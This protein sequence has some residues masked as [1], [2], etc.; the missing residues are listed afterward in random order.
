MKAFDFIEFWLYTQ[1]LASQSL[2]SISSI[3]SSGWRPTNKKKT[4]RKP[5]VVPRFAAGTSNKQNTFIIHLFYR[6]Y[7]VFWRSFVKKENN[8][9]G[10]FSQERPLKI[11][12][13]FNLAACAVMLSG[14][15]YIF[16]TRI[17]Q[18]AKS[19][20]LESIVHSTKAQFLGFSMLQGEDCWGEGSEGWK[21]TTKKQDIFFPVKAQR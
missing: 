17:L 11:N 20:S 19:L 14:H 13:L 9:G 10:K 12:E 21:K 15:K 6:L 7:C 2:S 16:P 3:T 8:S 1:D 4:R 18:R 5:K